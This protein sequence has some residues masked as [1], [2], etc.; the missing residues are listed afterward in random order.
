MLGKLW[1]DI[2]C[3]RLLYSALEYIFAIKFLGT[4]SSLEAFN[5]PQRMCSLCSVSINVV[6]GNL[7]LGQVHVLQCRQ[8]MSN[9]ENQASELFDLQ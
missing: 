8:R 5:L 9:S 6:L 3:S 7:V 2:P 1:Q 4:T